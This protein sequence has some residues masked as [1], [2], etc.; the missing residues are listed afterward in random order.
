MK[1]FETIQALRALAANM[2]VIDHLIGLSIRVN[3]AYQSW[4]EVFRNLGAG[5]VHC[6]FVISGFVVTAAANR[7]SSIQ[8]FASRLIRIYPIYW[9]YLA[10]MIGFYLFKGWPEPSSGLMNSILLLPDNAAPLL[11]VSWSLTHEVYFY[12]VMAIAIALRLPFAW[13]FVGWAVAVSAS[14]LASPPSGSVTFIATHPYTLEFIAGGVIAVVPFRRFELSSL[15][16]GTLLVTGGQFLAAIDAP[17]SVS[18][19]M[20]LT[21]IPFILVV[22]GVVALETNRRIDLPRC[23]TVLGDASYSTYLS[24]F[25]VLALLTRIASLQPLQGMF[26]QMLIA[27]GCIIAANIYGVLSYRYLETPILRFLKAAFNVKVQH[28][29][30]NIAATKVL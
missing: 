29:S 3:P 5:G 18:V 1:K 27:I 15:I 19:K 22:Y 9:I 17:A 12:I 7:E 6:F 8:F 20:A 24:H 14:Q 30:S 11:G 28:S 25:L 4:D 26:A 16:F 10:L 2:V 21:G 13:L 23:L